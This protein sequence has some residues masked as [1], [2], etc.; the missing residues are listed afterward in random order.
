MSDRDSFSEYDDP[1]PISTAIGNGTAF[2]D[3][4]KSSNILFF[5]PDHTE[6]IRIAKDGFYVRGVK[7]EQ[8]ETEARKLFDALMEFMGGVRK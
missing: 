7:L 2:C 4:S 8:D 5:S 6:M 1:A 3:T